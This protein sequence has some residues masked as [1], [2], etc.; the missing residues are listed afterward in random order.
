MGRI[1]EAT[2]SEIRSRID[3]VDLVSRYVL[4]KRAGRNHKGLCPFHDEK[5]PSFNVS[6]DRQI[7]HCFG[8]QAG[9]DVVEFLMRH[10]SLTFPEAVR[11]LA[12]ECGVEVPDEQGDPA[13][14]GI[15]ER[16][17]EA[18]DIAQRLYVDVLAS[19]EGEGARAYLAKRGL[20]TDEA[21]AGTPSSERCVPGRSTP[22]SARRRA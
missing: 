12:G 1:P 16:V 7:Y 5:T 18:N 11:T 9:G 6:P 20:S 21:R 10:E 19:A 22:N 3:I 4:L 15:S 2:I 8:C 13:A 17:F 14:R